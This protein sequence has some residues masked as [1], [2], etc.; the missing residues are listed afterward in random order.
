MT[1]CS[2]KSKICRG[3]GSSD[4]R[5]SAAPADSSSMI[6]LHRSMHSSQM[7]TPG[8]AI[9]FF[10]CFWL[11]PQNEHLSR[12]PV[13]P[14]RG[15]TGATLLSKSGVRTCSCL[16][17]LARYPQKPRKSAANGCGR[18]TR[19]PE[20]GVRDELARGDDL[21]H[22]PVLLGLI[23]RQDRVPLDV[24]PDLLDRLPGVPGQDLLLEQPH[25]LD[26]VRLD[27]QVG[28]LHGALGAAGRLVDQDPGVGQR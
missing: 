28:D 10:T 5:C 12:S 13:S 18:V 2:R 21:V 3:L 26:L 7:Y 14:T 6:S 27:L 16:R 1:Y 19:A 4:H 17:D 20:S 8:P 9:S 25:P 22:D 11:F 15:A 23:G 24:G